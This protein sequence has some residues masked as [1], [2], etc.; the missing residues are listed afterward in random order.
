MKVINKRK[1]FFAVSG[2]LVLL[3]WIFIGVFGL[4]PGID[5]AG[6]TE[7]RV[8]LQEQAEPTEISRFILQEYGIDATASS[9]SDGDT[10]IRLPE[11][12]EER[13]QEMK[14]GLLVEF[15]GLKEKSFNSVGPVI[16]QELRSKSMWAI[17]FVL[18]GISLFVAW[19][20]RKV[21]KPINSW[22][23][24]ITTLITLIHD[25]SIPT[26]VFAVLGYFLGV[27]VDTTI[28]I[29]LLVVLGFS[30]N[31]TIVVF[32][33]IRE[34]LLINKGKNRPLREIINESVNETLMRSINTSLTLTLVLVFLLIMGPNTLFYFILTILVGTIVGT[35]SS[36]FLA[37]PMLYSWGKRRE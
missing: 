19:A 37:S 1:I 14:G 10:I 2:T 13:H 27:E 4:Q 30:V 16:G 33:R 25:V 21:S 9:L 24:G 29:A 8:E 20:F 26:G 28:I 31:D 15:G 32:D 35:Y 12:S 3:S 34:N 22:K 17:F 18:L 6:G 23:Y 5:L 36:I 11:I 7:W